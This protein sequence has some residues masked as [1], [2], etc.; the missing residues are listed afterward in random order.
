MKKVVSFALLLCAA[1]AA[2]ATRGVLS[3][4]AP[5]ADVSA[6]FCPFVLELYYLGIAAG[7]SATTFSPDQPVT[8]GQAAVFISKGIDTAIQRS[9]RRA[10]LGQWWTT[11]LLF[12]NSIASYS[13]TTVGA[14]PSQI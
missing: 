13:S 14:D 3:S 7:T 4:C 11:Q 6:T 10:A 12:N 2:G 1:L 5:F 8:R 9:S